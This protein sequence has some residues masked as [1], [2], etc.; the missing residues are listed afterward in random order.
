MPAG[1]KKAA[2]QH[3]RIEKLDFSLGMAIGFSLALAF[4]LL[5][6]GATASDEALLKAFGFYCIYCI[7]KFIF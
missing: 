2:R 4:N 7:I 3:A 5:N 6:R 1:K